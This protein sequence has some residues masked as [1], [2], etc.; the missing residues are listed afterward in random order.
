MRSVINQSNK[1]SKSISKLEYEKISAELNELTNPNTSIPPPPPPLLILDLNGTLV[2]KKRPNPIKRPYEY[3]NWE[4]MIWSSA[5]P[6]N[7]KK[8]CELLEIEKREHGLVPKNDYLDP[9]IHHHSHRYLTRSKVNSSNSKIKSNETP[10]TN[11]EHQHQN[12]TP[13]NHKRK[14]SILEIWDTSQ[15]NL[16]D[17]DFNRKVSTTKDSNSI[18][19]KIKSLDPYTQ[20][21]YDYGPKNHKRLV[22]EIWDR[23]QMNLSDQ[24]FNRKVSTTKDLNS[25]WKKIKYLDPYTQQEYDYGPKN[26]II[27]DDSPEKLEIEMMMLY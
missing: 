6:Q 26:T 22:L 21:E 18:W 1:V 17:E 7:V 4:V 16:S 10:Q 13:K 25:I 19:K 23:S 9:P 24:D 2:M 11:H 20:Q 12:P 27:I 5:Q 8:M 3:T 15:M 14:R